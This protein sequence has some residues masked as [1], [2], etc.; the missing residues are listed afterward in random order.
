VPLLPQS[1]AHTQQRIA[2]P[3]AS[4]FALFNSTGIP[5]S[6]TGGYG[7][8]PLGSSTVRTG[9]GTGTGDGGGQGGYGGHGGY[10]PLAS[11]STNAYPPGAAALGAA[12]VASSQRPPEEVLYA[13]S[14]ARGGQQQ[15]RRRQRRYV[16][17]SRVGYCQDCVHYSDWFAGIVVIALLVGFFVC[18]GKLMSML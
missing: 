18:F 12:P 13:S 14:A 9:T 16:G 5:G 6:V 10:A 8:S 1:L 2:Q 15:Q 4:Q 11:P 3:T 17:R 7:L